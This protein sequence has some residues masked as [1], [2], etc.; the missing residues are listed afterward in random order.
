VVAPASL[1]FANSRLA[2]ARFTR[3]S[4]YAAPARSTAVPNDRCAR[5]ALVRVGVVAHQPLVAIAV[6]GSEVLRRRKRSP[7]RCPSPDASGVA[8]KF[9]ERE[10]RG[11]S[12]D[13]G[14]LRFDSAHVIG[15]RRRCA[16]AA[17]QAACA[18]RR[19]GLGCLWAEA[20]QVGPQAAPGREAQD[21]RAQG[22][23]TPGRH[24]R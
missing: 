11:G 2:C 17:S 24:C 1:Q 22:F 5:Q 10:D 18:P 23:P 14:G 12:R 13:E 3:L 7:V 21:G 9:L 8:A 16:T 4:A 15:H 20:Q 19:Y 6:A